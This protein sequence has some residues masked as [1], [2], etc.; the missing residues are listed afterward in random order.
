[1]IRVRSLAAATVVAA[2]AGVS[3]FAQQAQQA[4]QGQPAPPEMHQVLAGKKFTPPIRG[5][6]TID[7]V[8]QPTKREGTTLVTRILA[9]NTSNAPIPRLKVAE[10]WFDKDGNMIPGGEA[11]V[12]GLLQPGEVTTLEVR[13]PVNLKMLQSRLQF[14]HAN[15]TVNAKSVKS[16]DGAN[17]GKEP[18]AKPAA[19]TKASAKSKKK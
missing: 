14:S 12:N 18:A 7:I 1:M 19:A 13:T 15:G 17:A 4:P 9:K 11:A 10:T 5:E 2:F 8:K 16:L 6:A 3:L